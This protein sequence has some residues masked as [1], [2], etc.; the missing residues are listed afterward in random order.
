MV[1]EVPDVCMCKGQSC[2][3]KESC[4][5][6]TATPNPYWQSYFMVPPVDVNTQECSHFWDTTGEAWIDEDEDEVD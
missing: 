3:R 4:Y 1:I 5:R 6:F 2:L